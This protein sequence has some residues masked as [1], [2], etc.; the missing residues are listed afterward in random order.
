[1]PQIINE[2]KT[3]DEENICSINI[4]NVNVITFE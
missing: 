1:M 4:I 2:I 3:T